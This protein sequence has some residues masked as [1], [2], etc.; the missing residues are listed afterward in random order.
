MVR[1]AGQQISLGDLSAVDF[2]EK[3]RN[4]H[5]VRPKLPIECACTSKRTLALIVVNRDA[6]YF[7]RRH[8]NSEGDHHDEGCPHHK[9]SERRLAHR[10]YTP[11]VWRATD[12]GELRLSLDFGLAIATNFQ[13]L[14]RPTTKNFGGRQFQM[15]SRATLLGLLHA[16]WT[17]A[18]LTRYWPGESPDP[19]RHVAI[20]AKQI[21]PS[22]SRSLGDHGLLKTLLLPARSVDFQQKANSDRMKDAYEKGRRLLFIGRLTPELAGTITASGGIDLCAEFEVPIAV[23]QGML[24]SHMR[25][26]STSAKALRQGD[27]LT[28]FGLAEAFRGDDGRYAATAVRIVT[29]PTTANCIPVDSSYELQVAKH[30]EATGR[31]FSKPLRYDAESEVHPDF[32]LHD[33]G[34][35]AY[36]LEV[37]GMSMPDYLTRKAEKVTYYA[38]QYPEAH[39]SWDATSEELEDAIGRIPSPRPGR[40]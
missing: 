6:N 7:L 3:L 5:T 23:P 40:A 28:F 14:T 20:A 10:G 26:S 33:L 17:R 18:G 2:R 38:S 12:G 29:M 30:L 8:A 9:P 22:R 24:E 16:L 25:R 4:A 11:E 19:W 32:L 36:P 39:W 13:E 27:P 1:I 34:P 37:Y 15:S 35:C 21:F 31:R